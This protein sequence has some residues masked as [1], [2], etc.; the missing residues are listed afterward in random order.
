MQEEKKKIIEDFVCCPECRSGVKVQGKNIVCSQ[1][2]QNF[3]ILNGD[4]PSMFSE[5]S[6]EVD[7]SMKKW[8]KMYKNE[9]LIISTEKINKGSYGESLKSHLF[10]LSKD[11]KKK[12]F[13]EIGC[14]LS[15]LGEGFIKNGWFYIGVDFSRQALILLKKK[16]AGMEDKFLLVHSDVRNLPI[17]ERSIGMIVGLGVIEHFKNTQPIINL[18][19]ECLAGGGLV[20][21]C[22]PSLNIGNLFYRQ[23]WGGIPNVFFFRNL[24]EFLHIK[25]LGGKHMLFGYEL[26]FTRSQLVAMHLKAGFMPKNIAI[27]RFDCGEAQLYF[28][29]NEGLRKAFRKLCLNYYQFWPMVEIIAKK[30]RE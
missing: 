9:R 29:K 17:R 13:V 23:I 5:I 2:G 22:V 12:V 10:A 18:F 1:C 4:I 6:G 15:P 25:V 26:Q 8:D 30:Q 19:F 7:F 20:F 3:E 28:I 24:F 16:L 14:G 21:N 27:E 11:V